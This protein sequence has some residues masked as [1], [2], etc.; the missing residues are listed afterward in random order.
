MSKLTDFGVFLLIGGFVIVFAPSPFSGDGLSVDYYH[1]LCEGNIL[2]S[3]LASEECDQWNL[4]WSFGWFA[5]LSGG[6]LIGAGL[7]SNDQVV[8]QADTPQEAPKVDPNLLSRE[9]LVPFVTPMSLDEMLE[10]GFQADVIEEYQKYWREEAQAMIQKGLDDSDLK[11]DV[12]EFNEV[13][14]EIN[15]TTDEVEVDEDE[16]LEGT[17]E[18]HQDS[19]EEDDPQE[20]S[21]LQSESRLQKHDDHPGWLW[22][23]DNQEWVPDP[24]SPQS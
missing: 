17:E 2:V 6:G 16:M 10:D 4:M 3:L 19:D 14:N 13:W 7:F 20:D 9:S 22:D 24:D 1:D 12:E 11:Y 5:M 23:P 21:E 18:A 15:N 8:E